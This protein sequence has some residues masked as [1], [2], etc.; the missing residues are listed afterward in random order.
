MMKMRRGGGSESKKALNY[1]KQGRKTVNN[2]T[3]LECNT[4]APAA[5]PKKCK[6]PHAWLP[7]TSA[8]II[9]S[10]LT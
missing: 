10:S 4:K 9:G 3:W 1:S 7:Q 6:P 5:T 2:K 8:D